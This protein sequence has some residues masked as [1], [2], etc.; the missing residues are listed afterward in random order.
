MRPGKIGGKQGIKQAEEEHLTQFMDDGE[1][2]QKTAGAI[3]ER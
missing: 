2:V 3:T 1:K